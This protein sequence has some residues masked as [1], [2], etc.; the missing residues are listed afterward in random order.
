MRFIMV[1]VAS[2]VGS[3]MDYMHLVTSLWNIESLK[4]V[5]DSD[6]DS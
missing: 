4:R 1:F 6:N 2:L 5:A 3:S